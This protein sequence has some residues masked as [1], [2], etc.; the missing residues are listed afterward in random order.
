MYINAP[1][2]SRRS[3]M[4]VEHLDKDNII[5]CQGTAAYRVAIVSYP[6]FALIST[7]KTQ[8]TAQEHSA[9]MAYQLIKLVLSASL[10]LSP[11]LAMPASPNELVHHTRPKPC[12]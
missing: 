3:K 7:L 11:A 1:S 4:K 10:L 6:S 5:T 2:S 9:T 12:L 8:P